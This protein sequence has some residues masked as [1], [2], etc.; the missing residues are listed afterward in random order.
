[1]IGRTWKSFSSVGSSTPSLLTSQSLKIRR[2]AST[3]FGFR[4]CEG[5]VTVSTDSLRAKANDGNR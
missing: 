2:S 3:H 5:E 1:V 4:A